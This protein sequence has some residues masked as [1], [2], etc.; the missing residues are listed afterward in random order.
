M[1]D[2]TTLSAAV[3]VGDK[4]RTLDDGTRKW[5][6]GIPG[7]LT[8]FGDPDTIVVPVGA[9]AADGM[10]GPTA[11]N[12]S[13]KNLCFL[14]AFNGATWDQL[15]TDTTNGLDVDVTRVIPGTGAT[16]L[17]KAIDSLAGA[18]D[19]GIASLAIRDDTLSTLTPVEGDYVPLRVN[20]TGA[21]HVTGGGGG[22]EYTEDVASPAAIVGGAVMVERDDVLSSLT[23]VEGDWAALRCSANGALWIA[24]DGTVPAT[25]SGTWDIGTVTAVT[26]ITNALPAGTNNIGDVDVLTVPANPF[27]VNADAA[28]ATGSISAK[29]RFIASIGIP[30]TGT[31]AVTKSGAWN[32]ETVGTITDPLPAGGNNIG[33]VDVLT[34]PTDPFGVNADAASATG[35]ISAKL[36]FIAG[37]GIPITGAAL[38]SLQLIDN[39]VSGAG[40][41]ITQL[42][43]VNVSMDNGASDTGT[44]R[45]TIANDSTG[46]LAG[47]TTVTTVS[48]VTAITNAL[49][50]GTNNIG[51]VDVLSVI[52]GTGATNLGKAVDTASGATDTGVAPLAVRDDALAALTPVEGDYVPLRVDANG[53]L[54][55]IVTGTV[56][57]GSHNVTNAG[58]FAVQE[59]GAALTALQLIDNA[60]SGAG[61]NITQMNGVNVTMGNGA[62]GTGVQRVT[63]ANDSTGVL[64]G[65][66]TVTTVTAVTAITNALPAGTNNIGDVDVLTLP[67]LPAGTN[68]IGDVDV[69]SLV[70]GTAATNLGKALDSP[71]GPTDTGVSVFALRDDAL[72]TLV[73]AEGDYVN[74]RVDANGALWVNLSGVNHDSADLGP[75]VKIGA[76][77]ISTQL[78]Q[79]PVTNDDRTNLFAG[80]DGALL[81][82]DG[83]LEDCISERVTNTDGASTAM[84]GAFAATA[85]QRIYLTDVTLCNSSATF[86]TVDLR[87][88]AAGAVL[89]TFPLPPTAG[90]VYR[91]KRPL[92]FTSNTALAYDVSAAISTVTISV[93]GFKSKT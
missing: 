3:G 45:V 44:Q 67:S 61:F 7:V 54:W 51:D 2:D 42:S 27:G 35:S 25:Q 49:P 89:W 9:G 21:L 17:G 76:K 59:S 50:A 19:T 79:T 87:D 4:I 30:I 52:P 83:S 88:G 11:G 75:P 63:I 13:Y 20:S 29:L 60:V 70:P 47:V 80:L 10:A 39:A 36:R 78:A 43:G 58:I 71:V 73:P 62:S 72:S 66:T 92:R 1:A 74:F 64:A 31:V 57:T 8:I 65:V 32:I 28:S 53:A 34:V 90:V 69:L 23:P 14:M 86:C 48:A 37:T 56:T 22:T 24:V 77:A 84:T 40:F 46:V 12:P 81:V 41:N 26:A 82:R 15:R 68:N 91:F 85:G 38:T 16:N 6:A 18:T 5:A 33:D 93:G 55:V